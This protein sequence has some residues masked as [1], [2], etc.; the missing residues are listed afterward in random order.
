MAELK[1]ILLVEDSLK[2]VELTLVGL[3]KSHLANE[4]LGRPQRAAAGQHPAAAAGLT[5]TKA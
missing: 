5:Q 3:A 2:D 1:P 4:V